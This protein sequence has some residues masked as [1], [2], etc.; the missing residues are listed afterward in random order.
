MHNLIIYIFF[1][2]LYLFLANKNLIFKKYEIMKMNKHKEIDIYSL[3]NEVNKKNI[4]FGIIE[5]YSLNTVLPF[6]KSLIKSGFANWD[7][8][9]FVRNA[10]KKVNYLKKIGS[11]VFEIPNKYKNIDIIH[12]RWE[13]YSIY[14]KRYK[15]DYNFVFHCDIRDTFFQ[16]DVFKYYKSNKSFLVVVLENDSLSNEMNKKWILN[17]AGEH[18]CKFIKN[19]SI[20]C[21]G[22]FLGTPDKF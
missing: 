13:I 20:I 6:F 5:K 9:I 2:N 17:Y 19:E 16:K 4:I 21:L 11:F 3:E 12:L 10:N 14:L 7:I 15:N 1:L 8:V 22:S 18:K